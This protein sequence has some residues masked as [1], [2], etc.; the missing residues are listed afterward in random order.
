MRDE[1]QE[2]EEG[3]YDNQKCS[4]EA[5][6]C[7]VFREADGGTYLPKALLYDND[8]RDRS[9]SDDPNYENESNPDS[10]PLEYRSETSDD[11]FRGGEDGSMSEPELADQRKWTFKVSG[12]DHPEYD[13]EFLPLSTLLGDRILGPN[14]IGGVTMNREAYYNARC[15]EHIAGPG[16]RNSQGYLGRNI[17]LDEMRNCH[18]VQ[19]ILAKKEG[20]EPQ[21]DDLDFEAESQ[22]HLTGV[23][24]SMPSSGYGLKFAPVRH[25]VDDIR[26]ETD[27][28]LETVC[29]ICFFLHLC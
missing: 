9:L 13:T 6:C 8:P 29:H 7:M 1:R 25:G 11:D 26:A 22:Y 15:Y 3:I 24:E 18:T 23:A 17:S 10:E 28:V 4:S 2:E 12:P 20:W 19:C 21:P 5:G 14:D 27:Y 16:C